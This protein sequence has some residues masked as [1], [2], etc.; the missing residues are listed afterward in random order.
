[1][2]LRQVAVCRGAGLDD[3]L[4]LWMRYFTP[5]R[6]TALLE[7]H[8]FDVL[9]VPAR[10]WPVPRSRRKAAASVLSPC[11]G[12]DEDRLV[13]DTLY[14]YYDRAAVRSAAASEV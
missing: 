1:M 11:G 8:G 3:R 5:E 12:H 6:I 13:P 2:T 7:Q 9:D 14:H 4:R 10:I